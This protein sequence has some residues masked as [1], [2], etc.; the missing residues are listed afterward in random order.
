[1]K[2]ISLGFLNIYTVCVFLTKIGKKEFHEK[3]KKNL[4]IEKVINVKREKK[5]TII[6]H[7]KNV[8]A[9]RIRSFLVHNIIYYT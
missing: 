3:L 4:S 2:Y 7:I 1:M 9:H 8:Y 6:L 5:V